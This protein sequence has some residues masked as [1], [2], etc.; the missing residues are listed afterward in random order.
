MTDG[1]A[2]ETLVRDY[3]QFTIKA[4]Y[5]GDVT[6][7]AR[8]GLQGTPVVRGETLAVCVDKLTQTRRRNALRLEH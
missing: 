3:D 4:G 7:S 1:E 8:R 5:D 6:L 2:Y